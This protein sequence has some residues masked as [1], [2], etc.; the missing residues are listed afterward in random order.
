MISS[1]PPT[2]YQIRNGF[3]VIRRC[4]LLAYLDKMRMS[5]PLAKLKILG[6][7]F[8]E[9][10]GESVNMETMMHISLQV[11]DEMNI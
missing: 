5:M 4:N 1:A 11:V 7:D 6:A 3:A 2:I 8:M 10:N 9:V